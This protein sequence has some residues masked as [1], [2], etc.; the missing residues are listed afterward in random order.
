[1]TVHG[2][3]NV[4]LFRRRN[5]AA[6]AA[7]DPNPVRDA[8]TPSAEPRDVEAYY[9]CAWSSRS[10]KAVDQPPPYSGASGLPKEIGETIKATVLEYSDKLTE[11]S[12]WIWQHPELGYA[13]VGA[14]KRLTDLLESEGFE[15]ERGYKDL[16]T[17][18]RAVYKHGSGGRT[19]AFC[20]EYDAL[21]GIGHACGHNLIA[22][23]GV[24]GLLGMRAA[25]RKY[26]MDGTA[27][28]IG[29]PA[30]EGGM[31][32]AVLLDRGGFLGIDACM[33]VHP[34]GDYAGVAPGTACVIPT[35]A[36]V[37]LGIEFFG[38]PAHAGVAPWEG[39]N[40]LDAVHLAYGS[41]S[42]LRQQLHPTDKV[43]GIITHGGKAPNIIPDYAAM[44]YFIRAKTANDV[45]ALVA[46]VQACFDGAATATECKVKYD[47]AP[48]TY[49][50]RNNGPFCDE[51]AAAVSALW[52]RRTWIALDNWDNAGGS[53]DFGNV[54]YAMPACHPQFGIPAE[55]GRGN[56]TPQFTEK[57][58]TAK[59]HEY[60]FE[61]AAGMCAV[62]AQFLA[63]KD[64]ADKAI[65]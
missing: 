19:F 39:V 25:M 35:L 4:N 21:P 1:M 14:H 10:T 2:C 55:P 54:C 56:H 30:E 36:V 7:A 15:V 18:F 38:R 34:V 59:A 58:G 65:K 27:V 47:V 26:G 20:S 62:G 60:T 52:N 43:H 32:K 37:E 42:A 50:L 11:I 57:C 12:R 48:M 17:A 46:K 45:E 22:V 13:E 40:A 41:I 44:K 23:A 64:F 3:F 6:A 29:T 63:N 49:D 9:P 8:K 53:T 24:A 33:M 31:G 16:P 28:L 61:F 51:F 5:T